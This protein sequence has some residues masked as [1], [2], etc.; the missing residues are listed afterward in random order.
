MSRRPLEPGVGL[1]LALLLTVLA[2][3]GGAVAADETVLIGDALE[4]AQLEVE[5]GSTVTWRNIDDERHRLRSEDGPVRFDSKDLEPGASFSHRFTLEGTYPYY[6]HR[7]RD[8]AGYV[9]T[10]VVGA[11]TLEPEASVPE[12]GSVS[13]VDRSFQPGSVTIATGGTVEWR[14]SDGETHTVTAVDSSFDSDMLV[15]GATYGHGFDSAGS[16]PYLCLIHPEMRGTIIVADPAQAVM[17]D[18]ST[19]LPEDSA[20]PAPDVGQAPSSLPVAG[21]TVSIFDRLFEP[22]AVEVALGETVTWANDDS[23]GHTVTAVDGGFNSGVMTV[24]AEYAMAFDVAGS[25]DYFCAIHPEMTGTV[26]VTDGAP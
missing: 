11:A 14:N 8:E 5:V 6:D 25:F 10:I 18:A 16:F 21:P 7:N 22:A 24:G 9:G 26:T 4:P 23:E 20:V 15:E 19:A 12:S 3:G 13:I 1:A 2:G 17:V